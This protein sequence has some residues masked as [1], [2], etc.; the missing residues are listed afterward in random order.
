M[1]DD[2]E[3]VSVEKRLSE[4]ATDRVA[5][6]CHPILQLYRTEGQSPN[7]K[8]WVHDMTL[9]D[10]A[11]STIDSSNGRLPGYHN[12]LVAVGLSRFRKLHAWSSLG[13]GA[14]RSLSIR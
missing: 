6:S 4:W 8:R 1:N 12:A 2:E 9:T 14:A 5:E 3:E 13:D 7:S 10:C 11:E